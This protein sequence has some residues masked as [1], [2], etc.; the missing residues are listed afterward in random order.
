VGSNDSDF[1]K[2]KLCAYLLIIRYLFKKNTKVMN[3]RL[4]KYL[5]YSYS[6]LIVAIVMVTLIP[7]T[8]FG[9]EEPPTSLK[10]TQSTTFINPFAIC[11]VV[12]V[13]MLIINIIFIVWLYKDAK[14]RGMPNPGLWVL[15]VLII[16]LIGLIIYFLI[17]PQGD[18]VACKHCG[19]KML[20][21]AEKC[22]HCYRENISK[23]GRAIN[24]GNEMFGKINQKE[25]TCDFCQDTMIYNNDTNQYF[26][27]TC[28]VYKR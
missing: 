27:S 5:R 21:Q 15:L 18:L 7:I 2:G 19:D 6:L 28:G 11:L 13:I 14:N 22:P 10:S 16:G 26:C 1:V 9:Q 3:M 17:R 12:F 4:K 25:P 20:K 23:N 8:C 24:K